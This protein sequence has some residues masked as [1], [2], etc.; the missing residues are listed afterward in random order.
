MWPWFGCLLHW[1]ADVTGDPDVPIWLIISLNLVSVYR[2]VICIPYQLKIFYRLFILTW[3][4]SH[5][6]HF[7]DS[8]CQFEVI[9]VFCG[10]CLLVRPSVGDMHDKR[11]ACPWTWHCNFCNWSTIMLRLAWFPFSWNRKGV[12]I[13]VTEKSSF[14]ILLRKS[15]ESS[16]LK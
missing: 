1:F 5:M 8:L 15:S 9:L 11:S 4:V 10:P 14:C 3:F 6:L 2:W 16:E 13:P 12:P 7:L